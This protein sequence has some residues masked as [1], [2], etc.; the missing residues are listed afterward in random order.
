MF[1]SALFPLPDE[2]CAGQNHRQ[3]GDVIDDLHDRGEPIGIHVGIELGTDHDIGGLV[4][5][6]FAARLE[7]GYLLRDDGL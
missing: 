5:R 4:Q 7:L 6:T 3:H 1:D 2:R